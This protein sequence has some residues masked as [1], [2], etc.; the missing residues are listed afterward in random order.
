MSTC[1]VPRAVTCLQAWGGPEEVV[2]APAAWQFS[3]STD[4]DLDDTLSESDS[5]N[6]DDPF[7]ELSVRSVP[8]LGCTRQRMTAD[9]HSCV[10]SCA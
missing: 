8:C 7:D 6:D 10:L 5:E 2:E 9:D 1:D 4:L 3:D